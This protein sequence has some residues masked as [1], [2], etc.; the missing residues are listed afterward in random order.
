MNIVWMRP[1]GYPR[2]YAQPSP[3]LRWYQV[4]NDRVF[5]W[6]RAIKQWKTSHEYMSRPLPTWDFIP[7]AEPEGTEPLDILHD[8]GL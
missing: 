2:S 7:V 4:V 6:N 8:R 1:I 5:Y 3:I